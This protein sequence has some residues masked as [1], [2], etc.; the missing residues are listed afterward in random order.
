[1]SRRMVSQPL[2]HIERRGTITYLAPDGIEVWTLEGWFMLS[3]D[4]RTVVARK[5]RG[6]NRWQFCAA[7]AVLDLAVEWDPA[8]HS[9]WSEVAR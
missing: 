1:M 4:G 7:S 6:R 2:D 3:L 8:T 5:I 9:R